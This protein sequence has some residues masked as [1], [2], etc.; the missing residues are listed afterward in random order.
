ML[1]LFW[2]ISQVSFL[3]LKNYHFHL[4]NE[5]ICDRALLFKLTLFLAEEAVYNFP[6]QILCIYMQHFIQSL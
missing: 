4:W 5:D 6:I 3:H 2:E 1:G